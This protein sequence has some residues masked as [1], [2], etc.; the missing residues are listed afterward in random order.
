MSV[1]RLPL[2]AL[3]VAILPGACGGSDAERPVPPE[4]RSVAAPPSTLT[5]RAPVH[6]LDGL[7]REPMVVEHPDGTLFLAGYPS[8]VT[9]LDPRSVPNLWRSPD[10]G[11]SWSRVDVGSAAEG[12]IGNSDVDLT[13]APDGTLYFAA[14]GFDRS[15][16]EGTHIAIGVSRDVGQSWSWSL[17]AEQRFDDRPWVRVAPDGSAHVI[18]ND[19][20]GVAY[21]ISTDGGQSW[22]ERPRIHPVG[23]SSHFAVGPNG[24][25]AA[26]IAPI[27]ASANVFHEG[28]ELIAVSVDGG[29]SWAK[30]PAP[31]ERGWDPTFSDPSQI[32]RWVEPLAWDAR[33]ALFYLWSVGAELRL[34]RSL[35]RGASW[36]EWT[37]ATFDLPAYFPYLIARG[38]GELAATWFVGGG[39]DM[40]AQVAVILMP[41]AGGAEEP[42]V[43]RA[44]PF[45]PDVWAEREGVRQR[46]PGGEYLPI[47]FL[48]EGGLAVAAPVQDLAGDRFGFT[49]WRLELE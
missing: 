44:Q 20:S 22:V 32:P 40:T 6:H 17:L 14:M 15:T 11:A 47:L 49:F 45:Q 1:R 5:L 31:G 19:G 4:G 18:W 10:G 42:V 34:A 7:A 29:E 43:V 21:A 36:R 25:L 38:D 33:G 27:A 16:R 26:R 3:I 37:V 48:A 41:Q 23:G 39:D 35:D 46:D 9:G 24:E 8:Q 2:L 13:V 30:H 12:A 28:V